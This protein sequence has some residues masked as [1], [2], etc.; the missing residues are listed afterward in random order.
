M[1][2]SSLKRGYGKSFVP[3]KNPQTPFIFI[4]GRSHVKMLFLVAVIQ[5]Y[6]LSLFDTYTSH[7]S[8]AAIRSYCWR[9]LKGED[10]KACKSD[11]CNL[12]QN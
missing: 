12:Q 9:Y 7:Y 3:V 10:K 1:I 5:W 6:L 8:W 4:F 11:T 2:V